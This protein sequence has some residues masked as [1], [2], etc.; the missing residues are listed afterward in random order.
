MSAQAPFDPAPH[1]APAAVPG[2]LALV[3]KLLAVIGVVCYA[4]GLSSDPVRTQ[5]IFLVNIVYFMGLS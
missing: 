5:G 4:I 1:Y 2:K 3:A